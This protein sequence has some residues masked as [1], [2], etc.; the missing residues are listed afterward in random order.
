[1]KH[2][3]IP[4]RVPPKPTDTPDVQIV[5]KEINVKVLKDRVQCTVTFTPLQHGLL[6]MDE[7][8]RKDFDLTTPFVDILENVP[9]VFIDWWAVK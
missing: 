9:N 4:G 5:I 1:M 7:K 2:P 8:R 6:C 3:Q